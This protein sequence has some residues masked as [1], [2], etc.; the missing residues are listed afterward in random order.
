[1]RLRRLL[2]ILLLWI[3]SSQM[4]AENLGRP[5]S[6][7]TSGSRPENKY[8]CGPFYIVTKEDWKIL[9]AKKTVPQVPI[10]NYAVFAIFVIFVQSCEIVQFNN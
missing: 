6:T 3:S 8:N 10:P 7:P 5:L 4:G 9:T 2:K 1:M